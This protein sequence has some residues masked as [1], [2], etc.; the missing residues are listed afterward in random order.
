MTDQ[1]DN[2]I[3]L[4]Q[5][6]DASARRAPGECPDPLEL[7]AFADGRLQDPAR[8]AIEGHVADCAHCRAAVADAAVAAGGALPFA[9]APV[10]EAAKRLRARRAGAAHLR[11]ARRWRLAGRWAV[12][13][14]ASIGI[15]AA[16]YLAGSTWSAAGAP[17]DE[18]LVSELS[19]G[20]LGAGEP[21]AGLGVPSFEEWAP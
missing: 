18:A 5:R 11:P 21:D 16:G 4:W 7:A 12:S 20:L 2:D 17:A 19:F 9:P 15:C 13:A 8:A 3:R 10:L 6:F 14:A 1:P